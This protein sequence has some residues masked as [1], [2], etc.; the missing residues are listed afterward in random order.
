MQTASLNSSIF[1]E[2]TESTTSEH[3]FNQLCSQR[4]ERRKKCAKL[5]AQIYIRGRLTYKYA[6][7]FGLFYGILA[8]ASVLHS[9][10][11]Q[12]SNMTNSYYKG[13]FLKGCY[14]VI[15]FLFFN[16]FLFE[17]F[18]AKRELR[19]HSIHPP[20]LL[21]SFFFYFTLIILPVFVPVTEYPPWPS[22][23]KG[24]CFF[25]LQMIAILLWLNFLLKWIY[26]GNTQCCKLVGISLFLLPLWIVFTTPYLYII[27]FLRRCLFYSPLYVGI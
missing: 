26:S 16:L 3:Y 22:L 21:A 24:F 12:N 9:W 23:L 8:L 6:S 13:D 27:P 19:L 5:R 25:L 7:I 14:N 17:Y 4:E 10:R 11:F 15:Y 2:N 18:F 20:N 1:G